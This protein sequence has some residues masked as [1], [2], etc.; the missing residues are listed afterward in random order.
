MVIS[1]NKKADSLGL[2]SAVLPIGGCPNANYPD[3]GSGIRR[4]LLS[5][6][7]VI[8]IIIVSNRK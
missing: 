8:D 4:G 7:V 2:E 6:V 1:P 3:I 5:C